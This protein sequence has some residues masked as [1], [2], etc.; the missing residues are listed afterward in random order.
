MNERL[1]ATQ[2]LEFEMRSALANKE[3]FLEYQPIFDLGTGEVRACEAL[4][5]WLHPRKGRIP[6]A[7]FIPLAEQTGLINEIGAW[8]LHEACNEASRWPEHIKIAIN[9]SPVQV[10]G[11]GLPAVVKSA[12]D[13]AWLTPSRL[14]L[15]ITETTLLG[16]NE[17]TLQIL[18]ALYDLGAHIALDDFGTGYSSLSYL[19]MFPFQKIKVDRSFVL[20]IQD[21]NP[22][23]HAILRTIAFLGSALGM[24]T[25][26][27]GI[28]TEE[29]AAY[30]RQERFD[31]G[32]GYYFSRPVAAEV[33][34]WR[35]QA[36][37]A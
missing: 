10:R 2:V 19:Q 37:A 18:S 20:A 11:H 23:S 35:Q 5:R 17:H 36:D 24:V 21:G 30:L 1:L 7:D 13:A 32:Q 3:F 12:L 34:P 29:Q 22:T 27:E 9:L 15:E 8:V 33:L 16:D 14:E 25:T 26:V 6:P 4:L 28:E 31:Q